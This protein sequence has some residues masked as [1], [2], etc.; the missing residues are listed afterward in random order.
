MTSR[1][2][3]ESVFRVLL[4]LVFFWVGVGSESARVA[5][6]TMASESSLSIL[7]VPLEE[8]DHLNNILKDSNGERRQRVA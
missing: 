3:R 8:D 4:K 1:H 2:F 6:G 5:V 7:R